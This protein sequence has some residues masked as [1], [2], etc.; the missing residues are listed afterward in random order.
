MKCVNVYIW[1]REVLLRWRRVLIKPTFFLWLTD[2]RPKQRI[3]FSNFSKPFLL[4][5]F[6][7]S[8]K[9]FM[10]V[11][12]FMHTYECLRLTIRVLIYGEFVQTWTCVC[13][14][15]E[16]MRLCIHVPFSHI[17]PIIQIKR[18]RYNHI[19]FFPY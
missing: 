15:F 14:S 12:I 18:E 2:E 1:E 6:S 13:A 9:F 4:A 16:L 5:I 7:C 19:T 10:C 17:S 3:F 8:T 11:C